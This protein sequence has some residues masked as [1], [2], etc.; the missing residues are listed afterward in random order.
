MKNSTKLLILMLSILTS[1][2]SNAQIHMN[3]DFDTPYGD[4]ELVGKY[5]TVNGIQ[6]YYEEYGEGE[7]LFL[8]HGNSGDIKSMGN[9][10]DYFK[11]NYRVIIADSRGHGKSELNTDS[12]TYVQMAEDWNELANQLNIDS[13]N[14]IGWSDGGIIG[15]LMGINHPDKVKKI[16]AMAPNLRPDST[17]IYPYLVSYVKHSKQQVEMMIQAKDTSQEWNLLNQRL[18]LM[19]YQPSISTADLS[20]IQVPVLIMAGDKDIIREEHTIE[21]YQNIKNAHL[22]ILPGETHFMPASNP[23]VFNKIVETFI[24]KPFIRPDSDFTKW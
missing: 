12:L 15:L 9:Q 20:K 5:V 11:S 10:I 22:C 18:T 17:A 23:G 1:T 7:P 8:I 24:T 16:A 4:N 3:L 2:I 14:I 19:A 13:V 21:I 6:M